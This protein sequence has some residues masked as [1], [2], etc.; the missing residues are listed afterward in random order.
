MEHISINRVSERGFTSKQ[1]KTF[2]RIQVNFVTHVISKFKL[3][4]DRLSW[5]IKVSERNCV[6]DPF[7]RIV[8][9]QVYRDSIYYRMHGE[10]KIKHFL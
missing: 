3:P 1:R 10:R 9:L 5:Y 8:M 6:I 2:S 4:L 7:Q